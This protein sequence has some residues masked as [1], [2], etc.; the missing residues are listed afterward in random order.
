MM[1]W[2]DSAST[3]RPYRSAAPRPATAATPV[4][5]CSRIILADAGGVVSGHHLHPQIPQEAVALGQRLRM[6]DDPADVGQGLP[7]K[8][9]QGVVHGVEHLAGHVQVVLAQQIIHVI[10]RP[11][12]GVLHR[13]QAVV[14]R[15]AGHRL[16]EVDEGL[17]RI[18]LRRGAEPGAHRLVP[19][20]PEFPL[21]GDD[22]HARSL[23][24]WIFR[25]FYHTSAGGASGAVSELGEENMYEYTVN[26]NHSDDRANS[27]M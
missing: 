13:C 16:E 5:P 12:L 2:I 26:G 25:S 14:H 19:I 23:P 4:R 1:V 3:A 6:R 8:G 24:N 7:G 17:A 9:E 15:P 21:E 20:G 10:D 27:P 18:R 11:G 22:R